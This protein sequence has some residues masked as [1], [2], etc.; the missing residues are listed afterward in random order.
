MFAVY[1]H[2][3]VHMSLCLCLAQMRMNVNNGS[4]CVPLYARAFV[5]VFHIKVLQAHQVYIG[6]QRSLEPVFCT[7]ILSE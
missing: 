2:L 1:E 6:R 7:A 5:F 4:A 3:H